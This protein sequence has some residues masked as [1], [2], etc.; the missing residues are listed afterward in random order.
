MQEA[1]VQPVPRGRKG[2]AFSFVHGMESADMGKGRA[3]A[4]PFY[5]SEEPSVQTFVMLFFTQ[6][7]YFSVRY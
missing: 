1:G 2:Q 6:N 5:L 3:P 7:T 4:R